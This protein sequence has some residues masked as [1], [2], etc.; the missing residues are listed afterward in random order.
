MEQN[1]QHDIEQNTRHRRQQKTFR[2]LFWL[3]LTGLLV[4]MVALGTPFVSRAVAGHVLASAGC[5]A[6]GFDIQAQC[7]PGSYATRFIPFGHW[8]TTFLAPYLL[9]RQFWDLLLVW[10]AAV[11]GLGILSTSTGAPRKP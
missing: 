6:A 3:C 2:V 10:A 9:V 7:P 5:T 8:L 4:F 11:L 1:T